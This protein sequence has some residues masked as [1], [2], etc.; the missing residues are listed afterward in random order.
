MTFFSISFPICLLVY[1][2]NKCLSHNNNNNE[3]NND[4]IV[5]ALTYSEL[6]SDIAGPLP[7]GPFSQ[8]RA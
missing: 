7:Y 8:A 4:S 6:K 1:N 5:K 3:N 2:H